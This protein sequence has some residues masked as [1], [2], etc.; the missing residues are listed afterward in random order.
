[1]PSRLVN[2]PAPSE[3]NVARSTISLR[4]IPSVSFQPP[5]QVAD[6]GPKLEHVMFAVFL[7]VAAEHLPLAPM[8]ILRALAFLF[9]T[10]VVLAPATYADSS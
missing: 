1:M 8:Y 9:F 2:I 4:D 5:K 3:P 7:F 6:L 10:Q